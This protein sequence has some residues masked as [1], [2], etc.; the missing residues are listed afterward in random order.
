M[1]K[2]QVLNYKIRKGKESG[3]KKIFIDIMIYVG[4]VDINI[5]DLEK[6]GLKADLYCQINKIFIS[7]KING[8]SENI[9]DLIF[10]VKGLNNTYFTI[11]ITFAS[12][13]NDVDS[14]I[15]NKLKTGMSY[16]VT[17]DASQFDESGYTNKI[18]KF[19][20][21][22]IYDFISFMVNFYSLN[23]EIER[24]SLYDGKI[25]NMEKFKQFSQD[26]V[27]VEEDRYLSYEYEYRINV[28]SPDLSQYK[29]NLCKLYSS[30]IELRDYHEFYSRDILI[31]DNIPQQ[32]RFWNDVKHFS[33][34]YIHV[35]FEYDLL[36]KFNLKHIAQYT[37]KFIMKIMKE[38]KK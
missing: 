9:E 4:N 24:I 6:K 13:D 7:A 31:P 36:I 26:V 28:K 16:L 15:A 34:G 38:K 22:R 2:D 17:I 8:N 10:S 23:C 35:D 37:V 27:D 20:N 25:I 30:A 21:E 19:K 3:I 33:F 32:I 11:L 12:M 14:F 1:L 18:I 5:N 29:G